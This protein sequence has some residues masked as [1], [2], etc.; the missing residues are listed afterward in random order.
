M[1][2]TYSQLNLNLENF[3]IIDKKNVWD[4]L[5]KFIIMFYFFRIELNLLIYIIKK[6]RGQI[7]ILTLTLSSSHKLVYISHR[8]IESTN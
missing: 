5:K 7:S 3:I 1:Y 2:L 6:Q 8:N 4:L